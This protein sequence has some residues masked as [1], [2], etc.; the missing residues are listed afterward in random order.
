MSD[1]PGIHIDSSSVSAI[2]KPALMAAL[3]GLSVSTNVD[4]KNIDRSAEMA[5]LNNKRLLE[6]I[7]ELKTITGRALDEH[8]RTREIVELYC[9]GQARKQRKHYDSK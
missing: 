2:V 8:K 9:D 1:K 5:A 3:V 6:I 7:A 4:I